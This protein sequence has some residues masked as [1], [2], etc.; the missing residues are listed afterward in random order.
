MSVEAAGGVALTH[1]QISL[2]VCVLISV[3]DVRDVQVICPNSDNITNS[4][5]SPPAERGGGGWGGLC[6]LKGFYVEEQSVLPKKS[7]R[8]KQQALIVE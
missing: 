7:E 5:C 2:N 4:H 1:T 3:S 6:V 8:F